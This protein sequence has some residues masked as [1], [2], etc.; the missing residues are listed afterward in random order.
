[1]INNVLYEKIRAGK[2]IQQVVNAHSTLVQF[3]T[4]S[5]QGKQ[6]QFAWVNV[7]F[8]LLQSTIDPAS[9][10]RTER[11]DQDPASGQS[12]LHH[13]VV[14]LVRVPLQDQGANAPMGG[15]G[16]LVNTYAL[17]PQGLSVIATNSSV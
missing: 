10:K 15:T 6:R 12:R 13:M 8:A 7:S 2:I 9:G 3:Q 17:D 16:W 14:L 5:V 4:A 11:L 1:M